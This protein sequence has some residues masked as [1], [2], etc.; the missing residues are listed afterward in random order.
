MHFVIAQPQPEDAAEALDL[1]REE[2]KNDAEGCNIDT[3]DHSDE[4]HKVDLLS[5]LDYVNNAS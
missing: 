5:R 4:P 2:G 3:L 1:K